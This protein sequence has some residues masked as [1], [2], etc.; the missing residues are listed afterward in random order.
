MSKLHKNI[1]L[2]LLLLWLAGSLNVKAQDTFSIVAIDT[3]TGEVGS[4]GASCVDLILFFPNYAIDFLGDLIP[5]QG[6][7]NTQASYSTVNQA[8]ARA[9]MLAG[10]SPQQ[11]IDWLVANDANNNPNNRQYGIASFVNGSTQ[12]AGYTGSA[13][14]NYKNHITGPNY[15]I[16]GNILSG[17]AIL[18]S[19]ESRFLNEPGDLACK[20]MAAL[21]G[22]K[23]PGADTRC[24]NNGEGTSSLFAFLKVAQAQDEYGSPSLLL[25]V[26]TPGGAGIEPI[27]SLQS[28]FDGQHSCSQSVGI[29]ESKAELS[30]YPNP[31]HGI[32]HIHRSDADNSVYNYLLR[33]AFGRRAAEGRIES[34]KHTLDLSALQKGFYVLELSSGAERFTVF[35]LILID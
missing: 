23:V 10:D 9:R 16:Q 31:T 33:D 13:T 2:V 1:V 28:L 22:A 24:A 21:Q 3:A 18:D 26:K 12:T 17:Q 5:G 8:N 35:R 11:I 29:V 25:G 4:A 34:A 32:L 30:I 15:S 6:A 19:M 7:I 20:L 27:D 14:L